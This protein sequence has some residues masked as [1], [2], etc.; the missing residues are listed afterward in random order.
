MPES[1]EQA[2]QVLKENNFKITKQR[3]AMI[4]FTGGNC[5]A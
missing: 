5:N 4:E 1:I 3:R 2:T